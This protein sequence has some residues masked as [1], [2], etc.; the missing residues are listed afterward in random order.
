[1]GKINP[2]ALAIPLAKISVIPVLVMISAIITIVIIP[3]LVGVHCRTVVLKAADPAPCFHRPVLR[4]A[5][6]VRH[7]AVRM[8]GAGWLR[9]LI[10]A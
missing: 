1:M 10:L 3:R 9:S 6:K 7:A 2:V 8:R 4:K 5:K